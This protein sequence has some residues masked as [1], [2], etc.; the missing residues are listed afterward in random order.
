MNYA[1]LEGEYSDFTNAGI[2]IVPVPFGGTSTWLKGAENGPNA[3]LEASQNLELYD[4]ETK[5]EVYKKLIHTSSPIIADNSE[6]V[7]DLVKDK[8]TELIE[9]N[10]YPVVIGG[11]HT[12]SIGSMIAHAE[13]E[14]ITIVQLDAHS[15]M[16]DEYIDEKNDYSRDKFNHACVMARAKETAPVVQIGI[17]SMDSSE[18]KSIN[19]DNLFLAMDVID[20]DSWIDKA[21][22][23]T[24]KC[25]Y[26][27]IDLDVL[28]PGIMPSVCTPE[29]G[30]LLWYPTLRFLK[31]LSEKRE[32]TG[33]DVV[34]LCPNKF[35]KAP[36]FLAAKLIYT[37]LSYIF[38][39]KK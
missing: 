36:D 18:I 26:V 11:E 16:R 32:I 5:T 10:K 27:T 7:V 19:E 24:K 35:N 6:K 29:P 3:I 15:D 21:I 37:F 20:N 17:R 39:N 23:K 9:K 22:A 14:D 25:V 1:G 8:I 38:S 34:E 31:R 12:V 4:I 33:F 2:V 28:D 30:G 13:K